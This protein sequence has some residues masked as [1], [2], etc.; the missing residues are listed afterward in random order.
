MFILKLF[1]VTPNSECMGTLFQEYE[2]HEAIL[3]TFKNMLLF[4]L[5]FNLQGNLGIV[6]YFGF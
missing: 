3:L 5:F 6:M 1:S 4:I 2:I